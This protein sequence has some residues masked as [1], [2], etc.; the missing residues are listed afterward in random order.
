[1]C[2]KFVVGFITVMVLSLSSF[3]SSANIAA[4]MKSSRAKAAE[5][6]ELAKLK[7]IYQECK[8]ESLYDAKSESDKDKIRKACADL[9][10]LQV[11]GNEDLDLGDIF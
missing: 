11:N 2:R 9:A 1:M 3:Q 8:R 6:I 5:A 4:R 7:S 10:K